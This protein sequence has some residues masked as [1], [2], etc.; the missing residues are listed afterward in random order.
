MRT[1]CGEV[2]LVYCVSQF[3]ADFELNLIFGFDCNRLTRLRVA[4]RTRIALR[5]RKSTKTNERNGIVVFEGFCD[6]C[7]HSIKRFF[8]LSLGQTCVFCD[9]L[10]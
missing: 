5:Y 3:L 7:D 10:D 4:T 9:F 2:P 1:Q 8:R 6:A